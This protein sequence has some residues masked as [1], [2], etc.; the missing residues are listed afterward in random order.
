MEYPDA[1]ESLIEAFRRY[2]GVGRKTAERYALY[3]INHFT[4]E[5]YDH[6]LETIKRVEDEITPCEECG[7]LTDQKVCPICKNP[8]RDRS[9]I[10]V[11]EESK[12][13]V[14]IEKTKTYDGLYHVLGGVL[15][16]SNGIG[17]E[18]LAIRPLLERLKKDE[19]QELILATNLSDEGET[20]ALYLQRLLK[21]TDL[22]IT[23]IAY[24]MPAGG[25]I[26]YADE[27]T[28]NKALEGRKKF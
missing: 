15:S 19:H 1:L 8:S 7:H 27:I 17:P 3:T 10:L 24:G 20:T 26:S 18:D 12:D 5:D 22:L 28:L 14:V 11:V 13:V 25:N 23:R 2:P 9:K 16:P 4:D 21:D 6:F